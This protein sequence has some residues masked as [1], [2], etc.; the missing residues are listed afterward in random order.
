[1]RTYDLPPNYP[2]RYCYWSSPKCVLRSKSKKA[3]K[4]KSEVII[5]AIYHMSTKPISRKSGRSATASSA[6][7]NACKIIDERTGTE[8]DY[9]KK[10]GV[11][12]SA[13]FD[14]DKNELDRNQLWNLAE[15]SE[16]RK[17]ART[18]REYIIAIPAELMP[19]F[20]KP[21]PKL[22]EKEKQDKKKVEEH[23]LKMEQ[24]KID[25]DKAIE[26]A[27]KAEGVITALAFAENLTYKFDVAVDVAVHAPDSQ[28]D[29]KNWHAHIMSTTRKF[30][31]KNNKM[32]LGDK[33]DI[34]LSNRKLLELNKPKNQEQLKELR[35][36]WEDI[37]NNF[38]ESNGFKNTVDCRSYAD[39]KIEKIPTIKMG[40][41][42]SKMEREGKRSDRG[43][44]N[45]NIKLM[46]REL[47]KLNRD[48]SSLKAE[49]REDLTR[50][51]KPTLIW[52][53]NSDYCLNGE[54]I[55]EHN[56]HKLDRRQAELLADF[57][58]KNGLNKG[59][60]EGWIDYRQRINDY[61]NDD[62]VFENAENRQIFNMLYDSKSER[63]Q[64]E[65]S[66]DTVS[67][68]PVPVPEPTA[69]QEKQKV[70]RPTFR[71]F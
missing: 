2:L 60:D 59:S 57:K 36:D 22:S 28:G 67:P 40:W 50:A 42:A 47:H 16:K 10:S 68:E 38:L 43:D 69:V 54:K 24:Y 71:P 31:L 33:A 58:T 30:E 15:Q 46:N 20:P 17:D 53:T 44:M 64:Y 39:R 55:N 61:L 52:N 27:K 6:Y 37:Q 66:L 4:Q 29:N 8:H 63:Q 11:V 49:Y 7:R 70:I 45:R 23:K 34:E 18:A 32:L 13:C 26:K 56:E 62:D 14:K 19:D 51:I 65:Q 25:S 5:L 35:Q 1:M 48:L 9:T 3:E 41:K 12:Y 21:I